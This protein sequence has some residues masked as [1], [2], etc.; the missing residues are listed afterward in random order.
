[1]AEGLDTGPLYARRMTPVGPRDTA[2]ELHDRLS[3]LGAEVLVET[4]DRLPA[5]VPQPQE[6]ALATFAPKIERAHG[7]VDFTRTAVELDRQ[8]RAMTPW[9]GGYVERAEGPLKILEAH[10]IAYAVG[11][12]AP[13][14]LLS[15]DPLL[16]ACGEGALRLLTVQAAG[17]RPVSADAFVNGARLSKGDKL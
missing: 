6:D 4:L 7:R 17:R 3:V 16:V 10:P 9:P 5:L 1:M 15:T 2:G 13:G 8:I 12:H 14:T 11:P